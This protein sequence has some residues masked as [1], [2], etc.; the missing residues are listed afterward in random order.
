MTSVA[1]HRLGA[2][3]VA[4]NAAKKPPGTAGGLFE[5]SDRGPYASF[6]FK[7]SSR[8]SRKSSVYR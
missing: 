2:S 7:F 3:M 8:A 4:K 6:A 5:F 1:F